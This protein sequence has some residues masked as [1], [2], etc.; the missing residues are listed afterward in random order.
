[1]T[2]EEWISLVIVKRLIELERY[3][4]AIEKLNWMLDKHTLSKIEV[5]V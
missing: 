5:D 2:D 3:T 4:G 1:M